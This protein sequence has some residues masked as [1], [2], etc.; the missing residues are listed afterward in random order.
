ME[1]TLLQ[2]GAVRISTY[3]VFLL[4]GFAA[5]LLRFVRTAHRAELSGGEALDLGLSVLLAGLVGARVAH[6]VTHPGAYAAQPFRVVAI[7]QDGGLAFYGGVLASAAA[8]RGLRKDRWL[9]T[10]DALAA[11]VALGYAVGMLGA[12]WGGSFL[13]RPTDLP[14][15]VEGGGVLRHPVAAY[16]LVA[17]LVAYRLLERLHR[18]G[19]V[20]G[21]LALTYLLVQSV[22]RLVADFFVDPRFTSAVLGPFTLG[23]VASG[24]VAAGSAAGLWRIQREHGAG[25]SRE[26]DR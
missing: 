6:V 2:L 14:W 17:S 1:G 15:A 4:L 8:C 12:L 7:W 11:P 25:E 13:G 10:L 3:G 24:L 16:L 9:Q 23:Q 20:P 5:G 22:A 18:L 26:P 19:T 21:Q